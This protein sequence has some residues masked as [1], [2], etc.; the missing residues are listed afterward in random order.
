MAEDLYRVLGV[1][2]TADQKEIRRAYREKARKYHPDIN[3]DPSAEEQFKRISEA[4]DVLSDPETRAQYDRFGE[5]F[6]QYAGAPGA[7]DERNAAGRRSSAGP[8]YSGWTNFSS[9][10]QYGVSWED[11]FGDVFAGGSGRGSDHSA[12]L[13]LSI[14]EAYRGGR[15]T[16]RVADPLGGSREYEIDIPAGATDGERL[17]IQGAG[18]TG[19]GG[20]GDLIVTLR[21]R[22]SRRYR[23]TGANIEMELP[24]SP[25][26]AAL[27]ADVL[28][29]AP[30][31]AITVHV[32]AGS[33]S[34]RRLRLRGQGMPRRSGPAGDLYAR[35]KVVV[36]K[37]LTRKERIL[38]EQLRDESSFEP[39]RAS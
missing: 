32:P 26:E 21:V 2:R 13:E 30:G 16:V 31:G 23:L 9:N 36:P 27:G 1:S 12:E 37:Q 33:S 15:R 4:N 20:T 18:G 3:K 5:N 28:T 8:R 35:I 11:L 19:T 7:T 10:D 17:R 39:R 24:I 29:D 38:F 34:G 6:R 22:D 25:W 14:E